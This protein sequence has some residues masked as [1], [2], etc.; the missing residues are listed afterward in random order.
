M[1]ILLI[2][3]C[4][5]EHA[6]A[7]CLKQSG[8]E[9]IINS[10]STSELPS[11]VKESKIDLTVVGPEQALADGIVDLFQE[12]GLKI[13]GPS[14]QAARL[15]TSKS[16]AK[17]F[18]V[19]HHIPT[20]DH[21][22]CNTLQDAL[23]EVKG[24]IAAWKGIA[25]KPDGLTGGKGVVLCRSEKEAVEA[26]ENL[27]IKFPNK[28]VVLEQL[29]EGEEI[30]LLA[31]ADG[32][33]LL[34]MP[35]AQDYKT[36]YDG[37][38][39]PNTGGMGACAPLAYISEADQ[40]SIDEQIVQRTASALKKE[41]ICY[42]GILYFGMILTKEGPKVLEYNC[43]FGDPEAQTLLPLLESDLGEIFLACC[44]GNLEKCNVS[45]KKEAS[46]SVVLCTPGYPHRVDPPSQILGLEK[47]DKSKSIYLFNAGTKTTPSGE[48]FAICGRALTVTALGETPREAIDKC[49]AAVKTISFPG[50]YFRKDIGSSPLFV[51]EGATNVIVFASGTGVNFEGIAALQSEGKY[52]VLALFTD[53]KCPA[54]EIAKR[55]NI[56]RLSLNFEEFRRSPECESMPPHKIREA[57]DQAIADL[58][59]KF[60]AESHQ[61]VDLIVLAG[62]KKLITAPL[63][64]KFKNIINIHPADLTIVDHDGKPRYRGLNAVYEAL[65]NGEKQTRSS[66]IKVTEGEDSGPIVALGPWVTYKGKMPITHE[67]ASIHQEIQK[68]LS[69]LPACFE[70]IRKFAESRGS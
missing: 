4:G 47:I 3:S 53:R 44:D 45:W 59:N 8:H 62:Y 16:W 2:G 55:Y 58:I 48:T 60:L 61:K 69:D 46:C 40:R 68:Q 22:V 19:R 15:E 37:N 23:R 43:R 57:Y 14:M 25:V 5:R 9:V 42:R 34:P 49:Y 27:F 67:E 10:V 31:F 35:P 1:K 7:Q 63:L 6:I 50:I 54:E 13:F 17:E 12:H 39:G 20:A 33:T 51:G 38:S 56:P 28:P 26:I 30:T 24:K 52:K 65:K 64:N 29:L 41:K 18:M 11:Y 70:A 32:T 21:V 66:V 36:L